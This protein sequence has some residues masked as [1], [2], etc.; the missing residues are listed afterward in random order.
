MSSRA[1]SRIFV[2]VFLLLGALFV[3]AR[4]Q[5]RSHYLLAL[6][7]SSWRL[8]YIVDFKAEGTDAEVRIALPG[9]TPSAEI[10][11]EE[12]SHLGLRARTSRGAITQTRQLVVTARHSDTY[13]VA[14][15]FDILLRSRQSWLE[16]TELKSISPDSETRFLRSDDVFPVSN[17]AIVQRVLREFTEGE[18]S[19]GELLQRVFDYCLNDLHLAT[20]EAGGDNVE[21]ALAT[22][23][24]T[25]LGRARVM[26]TLCRAAGIPTRLVSGFELR[27]SDQAEPHVWV[28]AFLG[29]DW[30]PFDPEYGHARSLPNNLLPVRHGGE[31]IVH[32]P[33]THE[34]QVVYSI[35]RLAPD[36]EVLRS[37]VTRPGQIL[38]LTRLPLE[39]HNVM[40]LMLLLPLGALVTAVFRNLVGIRTFGSFAPTLLAISFIYAAWYTGL[41]ILVVV[42]TAGVL[43]R[44]LLERLHLLM[45]PRLSIILTTIVLCVVFGVSML[46]FIGKVSNEAVLLPLVILTIMIE[47]LYVTAE[48]DSLAFS[49]QLAL[50]TMAV[51]FVCYLFL[52]WEEVGRQVLIYPEIHFFTIAAFILIGRYT[53]YRLTELWRFRDLR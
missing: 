7:D 26:V 39:M 11:A 46:D 28:E 16:S 41:L 18:P 21:L 33:G 35:E 31:N 15:Q 4:Y 48:E 2:V 43:G 38:D 19:Q 13:H 8:A 42:F 30:V 17:S 27:Q 53:G 40:S 50:G 51:A 47:R 12:F 44:A 20:G 1:L 29:H 5:A 36:K 25:A 49:L 32:A 22:G 10:L 24:A 45:I 23:K 14:A 52:R 34:L 6:H 9:A 3:T 37:D